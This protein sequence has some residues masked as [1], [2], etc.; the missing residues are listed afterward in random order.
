[1]GA[2]GSENRFM[3]QLGH[4]VW[5]KPTL[6]KTVYLEGYP[7]CLPEVSSGLSYRARE[8]ERPQ[9]PLVKNN[10]PVTQA[11]SILQCQQQR[12]EVG[13]IFSA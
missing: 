12:Q 13:I 2:C 3:G 8:R 4:H 9:M 7:I 11:S 1:M 10:V 5:G 6:G